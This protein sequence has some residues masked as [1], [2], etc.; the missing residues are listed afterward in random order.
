MKKN[1]KYKFETHAHTSEISPCAQVK[2]KQV[3][4]TYHE[5]G[6]DGIVLT[7]HV[8]NWSFDVMNG[9][10]QDKIDNLA[11]V[12][13]EAKN[14][15]QKLGIKVFF[16]IELALADPYRDHLV[17]GID[18]DFLY[19]HEYIYE[20][21]N[22]D[23]YKLAVENNFLLIAAHPFRYMQNTMDARYLHGVEVYN[24]NMRQKN[25]ND[26]A[27]KWAKKNNMIELSGSDYHEVGDISAGIYLP[28]LPNTMLEFIDALRNNN[29]EL[30]I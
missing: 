23:F 25:N 6:Y 26:K 30:V 20:M 13:D 28:S 15:G 21:N 5:N 16:G 10:W 4:Q 11:R 3:V 7:D 1:M 12:Y 18:F 2:A 14:T 8:G 29:H 17:Y 24:G 19:K 22:K 27:L 9:S